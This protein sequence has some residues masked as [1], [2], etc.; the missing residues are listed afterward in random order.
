[1]FEEQCKWNVSS[2]EP[3]QILDMM[4]GGLCI[5]HVDD[6]QFTYVSKNMLA[7]LGYSEEEFRK[8]FDN[9]FSELVYIEDREE[10][11]STIVDQIAGDTFDTCIYR[12]EK[13][14]GSLMWVKDEG[15]LVVDPEGRECFCVTRVDIT[16][17]QERNEYDLEQQEDE[18]N[19]TIQEL[20]IAN[21]NA[22]SAY[23]LN[24]TKNLCSDCHGASEFIQNLLDVRTVDGMLERVTSVMMD[25]YSIR[26]YVANVTREKLFEKYQRGERRFTISYR[27]L[28]ENGGP[29][30]VKTFYHMIENPKSR[31]IE[32][33]VYTIDVDREYKEEKILTKI[34]EQSYDCFGLIDVHTNDVE[35]YYG[36][37][38]IESFDKEKIQKKLENQTVY[39]Y[40][41]VDGKKKKQVNFFY[42]DE[43][44]EQIVFSQ[45]DMTETHLRDSE[46]K[47]LRSRDTVSNIFNKDEGD[48]K[49]RDLIKYGK[50]GALFLFDIDDFKI[51]NDTF[52]SRTSDR[53]LRNFAE[54]LDNQFRSNDVLYRVIKDKFA[55]FAMGIEKQSKIVKIIEQFYAD[56]SEI[57]LE[58]QPD[59]IATVSVGVHV[60][61][62]AEESYEEMYQAANEQLSIAKKN[63]KDT[64]SIG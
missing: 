1:M 5:Y 42:F 33:V 32:V 47:Y 26:W 39:S 27:H 35:Y 31:D 58:D 14:D 45:V 46:N 56:L 7:M 11:L 4:P 55:V 6:D 12:I 10:T 2:F 8:K 16:E 53:I 13:K 41:K 61:L 28:R 15:H 48:Q 9:R 59:L 37:N 40:S 62:D 51:M 52:G 57:Y 60:H 54:Y 21:P 24:L 18:Y 17:M 25:D 43:T 44:K 22:R 64:F 23:K 20:L 49:V 34:V 3:G 50:T 19:N 30:W 63:G 36:A 29:V 38:E